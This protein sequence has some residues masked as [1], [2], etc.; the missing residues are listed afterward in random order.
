M[1]NH[2][3]RIV[4]MLLCLMLLAGAYSSTCL[5][6]SKTKGSCGKKAKW[7]YSKKTKTLTISGKGEV[8]DTWSR[9]L[10]N[11][12]VSVVVKKGITTIK[13]SAFSQTNIKKLSLPGT[14]KTI[15]PFAFGGLDATLPATVTIPKS[16]Q[17]IGL[18][19]FSGC[20]G[21]K[22]INVES[23]NNYYSSSGGVLY[24]KDKTVLLCYPSDKRGSY[25][26]ESSTEVLEDGAFLH[27][28]IK[29]LTVPG[30][31]VQIKSG[32][33]ENAGIEVLMF[34]GHVPAGLTAE[35]RDAEH[36]IDEV[37][38]P[39]AYYDEWDP[40]EEAIENEEVKWTY[41]W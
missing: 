14:L 9:Y 19:A 27:T 4:S 13:K 22:A 8:R 10:K 16:V 12:K 30:R 15:E 36:F 28:G 25:T 18:Y 20:E 32:A 11:K 2:F 37:C 24:N 33:F 5:A 26:I 39:K 23:G 17:K 35:L 1:K 34:E 38:F 29:T 7:S 21:L 40:L 41:W 31:V 3:K 6:A